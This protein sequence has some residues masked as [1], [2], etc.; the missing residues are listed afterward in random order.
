[1]AFAIGVML[2]VSFVAFGLF[3][4]FS[5]GE[6]L[7]VILWLVCLGLLVALK[8][9]LLWWI[10]DPLDAYERERRSLRR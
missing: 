9:G 1:M 2:A 6:V 7:G 3:L 10:G 5:L 8:N 4:V